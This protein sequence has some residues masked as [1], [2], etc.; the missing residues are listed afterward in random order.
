[1]NK[2]YNLDVCDVAGTELHPLEGGRGD[3]QSSTVDESL[4]DA[5]G[6]PAAAGGVLGHPGAEGRGPRVARGPTAPSDE[7]RKRHA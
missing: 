7:E 4:V 6:E 1:M 3:E 2:L 5:P